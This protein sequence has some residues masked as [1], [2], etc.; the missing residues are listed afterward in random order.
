[1]IA[2]LGWILAM[3][4][5]PRKR[6]LGGALL[7]SGIALGMLAKN[8]SA[9]LIP[10]FLLGASIVAAGI[11]RRRRPIRL[12]HKAPIILA[13]GLAAGIV[14]LPKEGALSR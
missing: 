6:E 11:A 10:S 2:L 1:S 3:R 14:L 7:L 13:L 12:P 9:A 8:S 5:Q 4:N